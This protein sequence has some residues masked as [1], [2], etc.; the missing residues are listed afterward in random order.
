M[1]LIAFALLLGLLTWLFSEYSI[2]KENDLYKPISLQSING[3]IGVRLKK[4]RVGH[5]IAEGKIN[6]QPVKFMIDTGATDVV[7]SEDLAKKAGIKKKTKIELITAN[8]KTEGWSA[9]ITSLKLGEIEEREVRAVIV[10][11]LGTVSPLLG[12]SFLERLSFEQQGNELIIR[13][14]FMVN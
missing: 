3:Q 9:I 2:Q 5:Y 4:S 10:P 1:Y 7:I 13:K 8:G 14:T 12:M 11:S 6:N